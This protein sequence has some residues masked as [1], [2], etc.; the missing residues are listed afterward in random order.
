M[1]KVGAA[2]FGILCLLSILFALSS[3]MILAAP[4]TAE[5]PGVFLA[6]L[7]ILASWVLPFFLGFAGLALLQER[8]GWQIAAAM[9]LFRSR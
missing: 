6:Y 2:V 5:P 8:P 3:L 4:V 1:R 7:L 9:P